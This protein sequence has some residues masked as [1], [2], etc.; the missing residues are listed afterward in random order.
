[1]SHHDS[2]PENVLYYGTEEA[3]PEQIE[4]QAGPLDLVFEAGDLRWIRLGTHEIVRRIYVAVRDKHW[5]TLANR[6]SNLS[7]RKL[8]SRFDICYDVENREGE[9]DFRWA[10]RIE[11]DESGTITFSMRGAAHSAFWKNRIGLCLLHPIRECAGRASRVTKVDGAVEEGRFPLEVS[12]HQPFQD[13]RGIAYRLNPDTSV[14]FDF[15]GDVFEMEDQRNWTDASFKTY[16]TP[17]RLPYPAPVAAGTVIEQTVRL[18]LSATSK[19]IARVPSPKA[20]Q[21]SF[22]PKESKRLPD[23]GLGV[24]SQVEALNRDQVPLLKRLNLSHLRVDLDLDGDYRRA[25]NRAI[26]EARQ[27]GIPLEV[28][29]FIS[30]SGS[31]PTQV[32][33]ELAEMRAPV[34]RWLV[35]RRG[36][37]STSAESVGLVREKLAALFPGTQLV[38][39]TNNYFAELNRQRPKTELLDGICYSI[40]PQVH[41]FDNDSLV[42]SLE[43]QRHT[44]ETAKRFAGGLPIYVSPVTLRPRF[45]P[46][47]TLSEPEREPGRLPRSVD[48]RQMS[49]FGAGWTIGSLRRLSEGGATGITYYETCGWRGVMDAA[50]GSPLPTRFRSLPGSV[51]PLFHVF[52][53]VAEFKGGEVLRS[54]TSVP[55]SLDGLVLRRDDRLRILV[56]NMSGQHQTVSVAIGTGVTYAQARMLDKRNVQRAM[57]DPASFRLEAPETVKGT[58]GCFELRLS[59]YAIARLDTVLTEDK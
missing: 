37:K 5:N 35:F 34:V 56:A 32:L 52:A 11:G 47:V 13:F 48:V 24:S 23:L 51:F 36:E 16:S 21:L 55:L 1:M 7:I 46:N 49:L 57:K 41:A 26:R 44:V 3:R 40:N 42:E 2:L 38:S 33:E 25:A 58:A 17:L 22:S 39:G 20:V 30:E 27:L 59:P 15:Q 28:S 43:G 29:L 18:S 9:I 14:R 12:P 31:R 53:D 4:L 50:S 8:P 19:K 10:G 6:I 45:N 54:E